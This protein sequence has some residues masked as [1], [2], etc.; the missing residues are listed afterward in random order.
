MLAA[1][2]PLGG[3]LGAIG[4]LLA[5]VA[6]SARWID[7]R[8]EVKGA[9]WLLAGSLLTSILT[10]VSG[11]DGSPDPLRELLAQWGVLNIE[12]SVF[13]IRKTI[14]FCFYGFLAYCSGRFSSGSGHSRRTGWL[15][16]LVWVGMAAAYDEWI[17]VQT[18]GRTGQMADVFLD[19]AGACAGL[20]VGFRPEFGGRS[21]AGT[22]APP[23]PPNT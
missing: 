19:L 14:H 8:L 17:Q 6:L 12:G 13:L 9:A 4:V 7:R 23:S 15:W 5:L 16:M 1:I 21:E 18:P 20:I 22:F 2:G 11:D 3:Y 10:R